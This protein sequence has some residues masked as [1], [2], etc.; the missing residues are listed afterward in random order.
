M[1][2]WE[3]EKY[4]KRLRKIHQKK[5]GKNNRRSRKNMK[6][7]RNGKNCCVTCGEI[8]FLFSGERRACSVG[9]KSRIKMD[10]VCLVIHFNGFPFAEKGRGPFVREMGYTTYPD[11]KYGSFRYRYYKRKEELQSW[12]RDRIDTF[13]VF[14]G[15]PFDAK[16]GESA[17]EMWFCGKDLKTLYEYAKTLK[18]TVVAFHGG[19]NGEKRML[20]RLRIPCIDLCYLG[21][22]PF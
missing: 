2:K 7:V 19:V 13:E 4:E 17:K 6:I 14:D 18:R 12:D 10:D 20:E 8:T 9:K 22:P 3:M 11:K 5:S 21:C 15:L 1:G 16:E